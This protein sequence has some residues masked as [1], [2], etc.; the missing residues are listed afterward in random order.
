MSTAETRVLAGQVLVAGFPGTDAPDELLRSG[1]RGELAGVILFKRNLEGMHQIAALI[2]RL[3]E[4]AP[5]DQPLMVAVDQEGGRVARLGPPVLRLP[6]MRKLA[7][8]G[9]AAL[10]ERAATLLGKQ[11]A[12]LGFTM[13]FAPVLDVDT[14][15]QNPVI[16]DRS[17]GTTPEQVLEQAFAFARGLT[18]GGVLACG[19]HFP[20]HG[21]TELDSHLA[22]PRLTHDRARL[23]Q[24]ELA[25]FRAARGCLPALMTAH[26]VFDALEPGVPAT[27]ARPVISGLLRAELGYEGL[28]I[29]DDLEMKAIADHYGVE[30]AA[31]LAIEAGCD[32]LLMCSRLDWLTRARAALAERAAREPAFKKRLEDAAERGLALRRAR[33][34]VPVTDPRE[35]ERRLEID[36]AEAMAAELT[37]LLQARG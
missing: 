24:I 34:P 14:N 11:L 32:T 19:K 9:D 13:D 37:G 12:A 18:V 36:A 17:F 33:P 8:L 3:A 1:S 28:V 25:P 15:P 4:S 6:P 7:A 35:L 27:L 29:S 31:C 30:Q 10:T 22:L 20:G 26:V 2:A 16:G 5:R 21:D 23:D